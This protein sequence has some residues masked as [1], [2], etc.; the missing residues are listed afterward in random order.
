V[1]APRFSLRHH[2]MVQ[3][4]I[5]RCWPLSTIS[6]LGYMFLGCAWLIRRHLPP[7]DARLLQALLFLAAGSVIHAMAASRIC[8]SWAAC[9]RSSPHICRDTIGCWPLPASSLCR[10]LSRT[11]FFMRPTRKARTA[12]AVL[13]PGD[14]AADL[15]LHVPAL[16]QTFLGIAVAGGASDKSHVDCSCP[17]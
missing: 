4:D 9:G 13:W 2:R 15:V 11:Q 6:Q 14:G 8:A 1:G 12:G 5:K 16:V 10:I 17:W 3:H 7:G